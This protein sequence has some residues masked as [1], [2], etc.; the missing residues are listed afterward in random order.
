MLSFKLMVAVSGAVA[1][2]AIGLV[3]GGLTL[4]G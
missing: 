3:N 2:F 1:A 4:I